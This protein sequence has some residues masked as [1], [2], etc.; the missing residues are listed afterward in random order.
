MLNADSKTFKS[1]G[2]MIPKNNS[3]IF[4]Q[5]FYPWALELTGPRMEGPLY[6]LAMTR[7][8]NDWYEQWSR[9]G[10]DRTIASVKMDI[11][12]YESL[13]V[14]GGRAFFQHVRPRNIFMEIHATL[15]PIRQ[16]EPGWTD[17]SMRVCI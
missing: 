15:W 17:I 12:G 1:D 8:L 16:E 11:E 6:Q 7:T 2:I 4:N 3:D 13:C 10:G 5:N 9:G 14:S